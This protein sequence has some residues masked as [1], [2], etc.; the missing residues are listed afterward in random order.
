MYAIYYVELETSHHFWGSTLLR[1][2][3]E[4]RRSRK[5][6]FFVLLR[7]SN[8][9]KVSNVARILNLSFPNVPQKCIKAMENFA[10]HYG[11]GSLLANVRYLLCWIR[12]Q[13]LSFLRFKN[14]ENAFG[15]M[16]RKWAFFVFLRKSNR[17]KVSMLLGSWI[18]IFQMFLKSA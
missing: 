16:S 5:W 15:G 9:G 18:Y 2:L 14:C 3:L 10:V 4:G 6:V 13:S 12:D 7:K 11:S 1:M 17:E 8:R